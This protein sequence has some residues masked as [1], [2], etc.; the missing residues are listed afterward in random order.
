MYTIENPDIFRKNVVKQ[1]KKY[2]I[3]DEHTINLER[4]IYN[5]TIKE[6]TQKNVIKKWN[7]SYFIQIYVDRLRSIY[8]NLHN[9]NIADKINNNS[10]AAS[11]FENIFPTFFR[12]SLQREI[13]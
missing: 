4:G 13:C 1:L 7:N 2:I 11:T 9:K 10:L 12:S 3:C 6:A 8:M 5:Y